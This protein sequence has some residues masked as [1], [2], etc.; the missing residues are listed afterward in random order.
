MCFEVKY[1]TLVVKP[2][3]YL[4][5]CLHTCV[6]FLC[7]VSLLQPGEIRRNKVCFVPQYSFLCV[8][9]HLFKIIT[10]LACLILVLT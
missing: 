3:N 5:F 7:H 9:H 6:F 1:R 10:H 8:W 2:C 4:R